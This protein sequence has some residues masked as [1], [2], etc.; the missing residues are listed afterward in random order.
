MYRAMDGFSVVSGPLPDGDTGTRK[1][2]DNMR[3]LAETGSRELAVREATIRAI[4][5]SA[6]APHDLV[7]QT[8]AVFEYVR[9]SVYFLHDPAGT[10]WLQSPR[11]TLTV[12]AGDC[13]DRATL[14]AAMLM[15]FGVRSQFKVIAADPRR[16]GTFT[17]VYLVAYPAGR[18]VALDPTYAENLMGYEPPRPYRTAMVPA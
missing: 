7:A 2:L 4:Q 16:P 17:H 10:E 15:S 5:A 13:D 12:G 9:D 18:A 8:R 6:A 3:R 1:T 14:L 11:Y